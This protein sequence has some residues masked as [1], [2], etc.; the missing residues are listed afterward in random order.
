MVV[1]EPERSAAEVWYHGELWAA[2]V[3][4]DD[5]SVTLE[6]YPRSSPTGEPQAWEFDYGEAVAQLAKARDAFARHV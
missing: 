3:L 2:V 1:G 6:T 5:G 4:R